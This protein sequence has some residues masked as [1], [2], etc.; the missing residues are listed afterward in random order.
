M[1]EI[2][3]SRSPL[4]SVYLRKIKQNS[5][6]PTSNSTANKSEVAEESFISPIT[7]EKSG[8]IKSTGSRDDVPRPNYALIMR[9]QYY[10]STLPNV[11]ENLLKEE[12]D[13]KFF[14]L[15]ELSSPPRKFYGPQRMRPYSRPQLNHANYFGTRPY[16][17]PPVYGMQT[18]YTPQRFGYYPAQSGHV[19]PD[20]G[21][22][23][24]NGPDMEENPDEEEDNKFF[25]LSELLS[26][27]RKPYVPGS[28]RPY[29][30]A[31]PNYANFLGPNWRLNYG[32]PP[33]QYVSGSNPYYSGYNSNFN[34]YSDI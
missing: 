8:V 6:L 28:I 7:E 26:P 19:R 5:R 17:Y 11:E 12:E 24:G 22:R 31:R 25:N 15:V 16:R 33:E 13:N 34:G 32:Q 20:Y 23:L 2:R 27:P 9:P 29:S 4:I 10:G 30:N 21:Y 3:Q 18:G 1:I 14:N